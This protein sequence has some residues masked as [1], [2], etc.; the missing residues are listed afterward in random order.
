MSGTH[1]PADPLVP[2]GYER[3]DTVASLA[4]LAGNI[5]I[6]FATLSVFSRFD[7]FL[8]K[9]RVSNVGM[10]RG[11]IATAMVL[12]DFLYYWDHRWMHEVRLLWAHHVSHHSGERY[13]LST[14]LRQPWSGFLTFWVFAPMPLLGFPTAK[15][16]KAIAT[17]NFITRLLPDS[18]V[19]PGLTW[20]VFRRTRPITRVPDTLART[21]SV[22]LKRHL[23]LLKRHLRYRQLQQT[24]GS[25]LS[26]VEK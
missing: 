18:T 8:F 2:L 7:R 3:K 26:L 14:A 6:G 19:F 16:A 22:V 11:S 20:T 13:N 4:M 12:W 10:R 1:L 23:R 25:V 5:A 17:K 9:H 15:T 21:L 24:A